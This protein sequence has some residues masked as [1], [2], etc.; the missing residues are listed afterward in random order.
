[1]NAL[2]WKRSKPSVIQKMKTAIIVD[3][4][5]LTGAMLVAGITYDN[6]QRLF[7][8][9]EREE[10]KALT[11]RNFRIATEREVAVSKVK[12]IKMELVSTIQMIDHPEYTKSVDSFLSS[13][14]DQ[15]LLSDDKKGILKYLLTELNRQIYG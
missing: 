9:V 3:K 13:L 8:K 4:E 1:M 5:S 12:S 10:M 2:E 6:F 11:L 15:G 7:T 14:S